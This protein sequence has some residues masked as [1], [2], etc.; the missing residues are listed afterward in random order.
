MLPA[1]HGPD[2]SLLCTFLGSL[3]GQEVE[4]RLS[5]GVMDLSSMTGLFPEK[6]GATRYSGCA[7]EAEHTARLISQTWRFGTANKQFK[8]NQ[9]IHKFILSSNL[10]LVLMLGCLDVH[11]ANLTVNTNT[12][13]CHL[14]TLVSRRVASATVA[15]GATARPPP[16]HWDTLQVAVVDEPMLLQ[17]EPQ[18][19]CKWPLYLVYV[20]ISVCTFGITSYRLL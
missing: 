15:T 17:K 11:E 7:S 12:E 3:F 14:V 9:H 1:V 16:G 4:G 2:R 10:H 20:P 8:L 18:V 19:Y 5:R 6:R 13:A